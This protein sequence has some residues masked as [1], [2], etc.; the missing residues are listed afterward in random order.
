MKCRYQKYILHFKEPGTTSRGT[1]RDKETYIITIEDEGERAYGECNLFRGLSYD[2]SPQYEEK[3]DEICKKLPSEPETILD[4]LEEWPSIRFGVQTVLKDWQ[5]GSRQI[6]FE[7]A[8]VNRGFS[9]PANGLIWMGSKEEMQSRILEKMSGGFS[10]IKLKI[11]AIDFEKE[12]ELLRLIRE[13]DLGG[14]ITIRLDAN[15]AFTPRSALEKLKRLAEF[16]IE[17]LEQP[18]RQGQWQE[19]A[20][21]IEDSPVPIALDEELI[22][23]NTLSEKKRLMDTLHPQLLILKPALAGGFTSCDEWRQLTAD[24]SGECVVTS[25]LESNIGLNAIAQYTATLSPKRSQGLGTGRLFTNNFPSPYRIDE[26]GL[27]FDAAQK[28][29]FSL[30]Q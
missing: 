27:H 10:N 16:N 1:F 11:G 26:K 19:M 25:A 17:Y 5:N 18:I 7:N 30:L 9:I 4:D 13:N 22:G 2:D 14:N 15:G 24:Q 29:D 21:I 20:R 6:I 3:L 12:L 23:I 8:F 28:W